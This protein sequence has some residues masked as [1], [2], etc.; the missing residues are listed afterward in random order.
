MRQFGG[1]FPDRHANVP[2]CRRKS[3]TVGVEK[4]EDHR[5]TIPRSTIGHGEGIWV[6]DWPGGRLRP[7]G[8]VDAESRQDRDKEKNMLHE[9]LA[10]TR[11]AAP[12]LRMD[13]RLD[14]F[15]V[16]CVVLD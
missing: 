9:L 1:A 14:Q 2:G 8:T 5:R 10:K 7:S 13:V 16:T 11:E 15:I 12:Q 3:V 6:G 4:I